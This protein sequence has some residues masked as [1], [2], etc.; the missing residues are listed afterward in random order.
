MRRAASLAGGI[1]CACVAL[2]VLAACGGGTGGGGTPS[3]VVAQVG[4]HAITKAALSEW[5]TETIGQDFFLTTSHQAP[6][7]L[8]SEPPDYQ[9]CVSVVNKLRAEASKPPLSEAVAMRRCEELYRAV[10]HQALAYLV[11]SFWRLDLYA[12]YGITVTPAQLQRTLQRFKASNYPNPGQFQQ[13]L[14]GRRRTLP[15]ELFIITNNILSEELKERLLN[16]GQ[17]LGAFVKA[18]E[19]ALISEPAICNPGYVVEDCRGYQRPAE[20][21][22]RSDAGA[23][24]PLLE[25]IVR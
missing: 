14:A 22:V 5:I 6:L 7:G 3:T 23:P 21:A 12:R 18:S 17:S 15:Q 19:R 4:Q 8:V 2:A 16:R 11:T 10:E 13:V 20:S 9:R 25:E 24:G 1:A